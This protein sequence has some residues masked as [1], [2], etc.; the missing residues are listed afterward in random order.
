MV[1][2]QSVNTYENMVFSKKIMDQQKKRYKC[3]FCTSDYHVFRAGL[4]SRKAGIRRCSGIGSRTVAYFSNNAV[5]PEYVPAMMMQKK[6]HLIAAGIL[7]LPW[8]CSALVLL[9][10]LILRLL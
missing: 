8:I 4:L 1:E 2:N 10:A 9:A 5:I 7:C 6:F 3:L